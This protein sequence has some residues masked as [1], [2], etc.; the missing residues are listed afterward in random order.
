[1]DKEKRTERMLPRIKQTVDSV[2]EYLIPH[3][4]GC[5]MSAKDYGQKGA[6]IITSLVNRKII[7]KTNL[8]RGEYKY[9]W[10]A[11]MHPTTTLYRSIALEIQAEQRMYQE[12]LKEKKST[13]VQEAPVSD[14]PAPKVAKPDK[15]Y[16][17]SVVSD[18]LGSTPQPPV[19]PVVNELLEEKPVEKSPLDEIKEMW[20]RMKE[21]GV[22]I[23]NN[24]LVLTEVKVYKTVLS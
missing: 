22:T 20:E 11:T 15:T 14:D 18:L 3:P 2:Y 5:G 23:E 6:R 24:Q 1:M 4:D 19:V 7:E 8:G 12:R 13:K 16:P 21:L 17:L 10:V 9:K